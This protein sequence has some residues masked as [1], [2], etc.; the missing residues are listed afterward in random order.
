VARLI[1]LLSDTDFCLRDVTS[2]G[3]FS[4]VYSHQ[5]LGSVRVCLGP[6][7]NHY[8]CESTSLNSWCAPTLFSWVIFHCDVEAGLVK[9]TELQSLVNDLYSRIEINFQNGNNDLKV[10]TCY[11]I[12]RERCRYPSTT[13]WKIS[14]T[15]VW[16]TA[17]SRRRESTDD[18]ISMAYRF[19]SIAFNPLP[20]KHF[21]NMDS[22]KNIR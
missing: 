1:I 3:D 12:I 17:H 9:S 22:R 11:V 21:S 15:E 10:S 6:L 20:N 18:F 19:F 13:F 5:L 8:T 4:G 14:K 2:H 7:R 16:K